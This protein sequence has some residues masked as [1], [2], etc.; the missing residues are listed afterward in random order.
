[1]PW[2]I[3]SSHRHERINYCIDRLRKISTSLS[4]V[5]DVRVFVGIVDD[6]NTKFVVLIRIIYH[7]WK[8]KLKEKSVFLKKLC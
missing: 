2:A 6:N 5:S 8:K 1:M 4:S 7:N 3:D